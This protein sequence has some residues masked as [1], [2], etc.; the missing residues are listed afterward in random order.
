MRVLSLLKISGQCLRGVLGVIEPGAFAAT[1]ENSQVRDMFIESNINAIFS[2]LAVGD[3]RW[4][5]S[6][7]VVS[8]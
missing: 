4:D 8:Y 1:L 3:G 2:R 5:S 6:I 7:P